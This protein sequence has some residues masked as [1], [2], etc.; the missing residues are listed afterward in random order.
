MGRIERVED[1]EQTTGNL[2]TWAMQTV[3]FTLMVR[4]RDLGTAI[5]DEHVGE[6]F[7]TAAEV[8]QKARAQ[9][10]PA[11]RYKSHQLWMT[12]VADEVLRWAQDHLER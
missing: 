11:D 9:A 8:Y 3:L 1:P 10:G 5:P 12:A 4:A 6:A 7:R 2:K